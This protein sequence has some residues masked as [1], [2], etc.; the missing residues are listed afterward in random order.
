MAEAK[1]ELRE[2]LMAR[3]GELGEAVRAAADERIAHAV[4]DWAGF[5]EASLVLSYVSV[6]AEVDTRALITAALAQGQTGG[7]AALRA[8]HA[9]HGVVPYRGTEVA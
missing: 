5:R 6:G 1:V 3:R 9:P 2:E 8:G 4:L 7:G